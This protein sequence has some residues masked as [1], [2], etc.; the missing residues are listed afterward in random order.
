MESSLKLI[1]CCT[2]WHSLLKKFNAQIQPHP[3]S[4]LHLS[5]P[6]CL[7]ENWCPSVQTRVSQPPC[8]GTRAWFY[9]AVSW[10]CLVAAGDTVF[11]FFKRECS[12]RICAV[13]T[14]GCL[15]PTHFWKLHRVVS[16]LEGKQVCVLFLGSLAELAVWAGPGH[17]SCWSSS[18]GVWRVL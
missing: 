16:I 12:H 1:W 2:T 5:S 8:P 14:P 9:P 4:P 17:C 7:E 10:M 3:D 6:R 13:A 11:D 18:A 15:H